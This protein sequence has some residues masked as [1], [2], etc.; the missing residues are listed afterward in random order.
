[1]IFKK[2]NP[3]ESGGINVEKDMSIERA[4]FVY[5]C[6]HNNR[7]MYCNVVNCHCSHESIWDN[8]MC[9]DA[10][11]AE[12]IVEHYMNTAIQRKQE[13]YDVIE[14]VLFNVTVNTL[15][16][17][18]YYTKEEACVQAIGV[19]RELIEKTDIKDVKEI[20]EQALNK[21]NK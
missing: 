6:H 17:N 21:Y 13:D 12:E 18:F 20:Y 14:L 19:M 8:E 10:K 2:V 15:L 3:R 11:K 5:K 1:M 9:E 4:W 7:N 16:S